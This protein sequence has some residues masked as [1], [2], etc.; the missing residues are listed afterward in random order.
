[1][2]TLSIV[3]IGGNT[4]ENEGELQ[5][6]LELFSAIHSPKILVHGGGKIANKMLSKLS[7]I[8][9]MIDGRRITNKETLEVVTMVYAGLVNKKIV[10]HLQKLN[11]NAIGLSGAD[12]N[13]IT[14]HK[15]E[16]KEI[17]YGFVGDIDL[18]DDKKLRG[19]LNMGLSPI[20]C[21]IT[22]DTKGQL[23]NTNADTV[24]SKIASALS[25]E[26]KTVLYYCFEHDGVL[27]DMKDP[28]TV[29]Q[30]IDSESYANLVSKGVI[31]DG[32]LPK[33]FNCFQALED[34]VAEVRIGNLGLFEK[35][36]TNFTSLVL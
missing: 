13:T 25:L 7:I 29:I 8:P 32:M 27:L 34:G 23:L 17:D 24:A 11:C 3:K 16:V 20:F 36:S 6:L 33:L 10:A 9:E 28:S 1:M 15:R 35:E 22:H 30:K 5:K 31:T 19:L 18:V 21:A 2:E 12:A 4:I 26:F 14:A